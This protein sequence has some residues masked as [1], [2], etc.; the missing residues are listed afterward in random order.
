MNTDVWYDAAP[1]GVHTI[2]N[3]V[4]NISMKSCASRMYTNNSVKATRANVL[5]KSGC[6]SQEIMTVTG[7]KNVASLASYALGPTLNNFS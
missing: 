7:H 6:Q 3:F 1:V 5:K 4:K 2:N